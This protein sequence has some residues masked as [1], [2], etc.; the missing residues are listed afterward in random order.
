MTTQ[1]PIKPTRPSEGPLD[2]EADRIGV[3]LEDAAVDRDRCGW[4]PL[5]PTP[6]ARRRRPQGRAPAVEARPLALLE[7]LLA[8]HALDLPGAGTSTPPRDR[9][10]EQQGGD[11]DERAEGDGED[12]RCSARSLGTMTTATI[13][14]AIAMAPNDAVVHSTM[15]AAT[16]RRST[17]GTSRRTAGWRDEHPEVTGVVRVREPAVGP[18]PVGDDERAATCDQQRRADARSA[19]LCRS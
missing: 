5:G 10:G 12:R 19:V 13:T 15:A 8:D 6:A 17:S 4:M 3:D 2:Q 7:A 18:P 11:D 14:T 1:K 9:L 16:G